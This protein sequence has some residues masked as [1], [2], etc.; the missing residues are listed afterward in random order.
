MAAN[1]R[2]LAAKALFQVVD[3]G[4]S[5]SDVLPELQQK[6][7]AKDKALLQ[8][9][10]YGVLR[11]LPELEASLKDLVT[12]PL[13]GK[14]RSTHF[15]MLV[16][17]YQLKYMRIPDHAA[18][19]ETVNA[20]KALKTDFLRGMVNGVLR[21]LQRNQP[22]IDENASDPVKFNHPSWFIKQIKNAYPQQWQ[23]ILENNQ[24]KPPMWLRANARTNSAQEYV[25]LL[26]QANISV[27][28]IDSNSDAILLEKPTDVSVLPGFEQGA[29]SVQDGAAQQAATLIN[30][31]ANERILDICAAPG[32]KTCHMLELTPDIAEMVAIDIDGNRLARV[33]ENLERISLNA[34]L[35]EADASQPKTWWD[36]KQFDRILL[37]APCSAT[38][39]I[40]RHPDIKWLRKASDIDVLVEL[41]Q[42]ILD[43]SWQ[44]LKPGGTLLYATCSI[45]P[46]ENKDQVDAFLKRQSDATLVPIEQSQD[47][48][49]WQIL[50]NEHSMDGF[51]YAKI[52]KS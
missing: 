51:Y 1:I 44:L 8:E 3:K 19:N 25:S 50:P 28:R 36:G 49:G 2:A 13:K 32:G 24:H 20:T 42:Q 37:D 43:A 12:K 27:V 21:N 41:Q 35:I 16:G 45:L 10:C 26:G 52:M 17:A 23:N 47:D 15:L 6:A 30:C 4:R 48:I 29:V 22:S 5:L 31:Q 9:I 39:V 40:R 7:E 38:G 33:Q 46:Q 18:I 14:T 11:V 34:E